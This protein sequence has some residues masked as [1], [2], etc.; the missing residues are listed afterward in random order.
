MKIF[1]TITNA[2]RSFMAGVVSLL[3]GTFVPSAAIAADLRVAKPRVH[4]FVPATAQRPR[5]SVRL[6]FLD[7][8]I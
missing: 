5:K 6:P 8:L 7:P 4:G 3:A 1:E 2:P